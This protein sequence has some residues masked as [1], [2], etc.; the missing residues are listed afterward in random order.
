VNK[1]KTVLLVAVALVAVFAIGALAFRS[2][3]DQKVAETLEDNP[4]IV[5]RPTAKTIGPDDARVHI[6]EFMDPGCETCA[7][8]YPLVKQIIDENP[9]KVKLSIRYLPLHQGADTMVKVLEAADKQGR[10]WETL[11]LLFGTQAQWASHHQPQPDK[12]WPLL[13]T[14][15]LDVDKLRQDM[16]APEVTQVLQR[17]MAD[18][19]LLGL[20]KTPSFFVN[21]QPLQ[22]FGLEQLRQ[23]V[24]MNVAR[25]YP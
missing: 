21:E 25:E 9:G 18:A 10:Y 7:V 4:S 22:Q 3:S 14:V 1:Q 17:D 13:P 20:R 15:G 23:L 19:E 5:V 16:N 11:R 6:V 24:A 8:F 12:I 2:A